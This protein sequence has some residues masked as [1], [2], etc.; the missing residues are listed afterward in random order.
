MV[1]NTYK[2]HSKL[3]LNGKGQ[4]LEDTEKLG[5]RIW[6][7]AHDVSDKNPLLQRLCTDAAPKLN[8]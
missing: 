8:T 7:P 3:I 4:V 1:Y 5:L 6:H 2:I